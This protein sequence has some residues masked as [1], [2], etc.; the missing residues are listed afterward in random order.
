MKPHKAEYY[1]IAHHTSTF[2]LDLTTGRVYT[3]LNP[4]EDIGVPCQKELFDLELLAEK[5]QS[6]LDTSGT[7]MEELQRIPL[8]QKIAAPADIMDLEEVEFKIHQYCQLWQLYAEISVELTRKSKLS[9]ESAITACK[10]YGSYI[11][12]ILQQVDEVMKLF[13]MEKE[14]R[15]IK[16]REH[17]PVPQIIPQGTKIETN[18][19][20]NKVLEAVDKE[21]I[22]MIKA[23]RESEEIYEKE[24][25]EAR[26]RDQ[27]LRLTRQT[28]RSDFNFLTMV[29]STPIRNNTTRP[30]PLERETVVHFD[31]NA[32]HH[33]Y[34]PTNPT[35]NGDRYE[36]PANDS[37]LQGAVMTNTTSATGCNKPWRCNNGANTATHMYPQTCT[38]RPSGHNSYYN[39]L[40]NSSDNR[41]GPTC[42]RCGEQGHMRLK[43]GKDTV[44]CTHCRSS[45]H[46]IKACRKHHNN[47]PSP[48]N[49]HVPT[50]YHPTA[51]PPPLL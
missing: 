1:S 16:N 24:Q 13:A 44:F 10:M 40:P 3:Y 22:E 31:T 51:T 35:T 5:L 41:N 33:F 2:E 42:F 15:I 38:T 19:D 4:P 21:E 17:F 26:N 8:V 46:D 9:R 30:D 6:D 25:E 47:T 7:H 18:H 28:S 20:K 45:N 37:I 49:S 14:L 29:N 43:S 12:D 48:T 23:V 34:P 50:G 27:Q 39:N 32:V 36:P 11:S